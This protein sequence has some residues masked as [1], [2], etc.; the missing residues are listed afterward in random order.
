MKIGIFKNFTKFTG[1]HLCQRSFLDK[2]INLK[3]V[4]LLKK[5]SGTDVFQYGDIILNRS[6]N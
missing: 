2:V 3:S 4:T 5:D 6:N 1:K